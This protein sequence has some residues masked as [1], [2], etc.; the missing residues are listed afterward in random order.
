M[1]WTTPRTWSVGELVTAAMQNTHV[2][3]NLNFLVQFVKDNHAVTSS[4]STYNITGTS[5]AQVGSLSLTLTTIDSTSGGSAYDTP[6]LLLARFNTLLSSITLTVRWWNNTASAVPSVHSY[7]LAS[8][9]NHELMLM[10][11]DRPSTG[12]NT[13]HLQAKVS[14]GTAQILRVQLF[15][16]EFA[17]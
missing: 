14:S 15:A 10:A 11:V 16:M 12:A 3:D 4:A 6:V 17:R 8:D 5:F 1:A 7:E 9:N 13:Y 2:R